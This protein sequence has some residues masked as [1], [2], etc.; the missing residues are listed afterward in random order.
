VA[1]S[2]SIMPE[3]LRLRADQRAVKQILLNLLSNAIKFTD[4]RGKVEVAA[5]AADGAV[6]L[7]VRDTGIGIPA[8]VLPR[9]ARPFE[10]AS[11]DPAR[12]HGGSGLGLALVK[13]LAQ[14]HGGTF[15]IQ[16]EQG[17][18]TEVTVTLPLEGDAAR[19]A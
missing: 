13:S 3:N 9:L 12:A 11:N 4:A 16:S 6:R 18:G 14:L 19:A 17:F 5:E 15:A 8:D 1:I 7:T 10:Q 2:T